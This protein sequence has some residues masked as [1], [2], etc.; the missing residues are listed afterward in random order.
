MRQSMS[1]ADYFVRQMQLWG[2]DTVF[3]VPG[4]T[5]L[6]LLESL[7]S[8]GDVRFVVCRHG[9]AAALM[10][11][12]YAKATGK[13]AACV[14]D[15]GP[16]AVQILNGVYDAYMD[17]VPVLALTG[18]FPTDRAAGR[19]PRSGD[20]RP[21]Y[22]AATVADETVRAAAE[23]PR[24][25]GGAL[26]SMA[27]HGRPVRV[28][29]PKD[30][31]AES[32]AQPQFVEHPESSAYA[33]NGRG[34]ESEYGGNVR[35]GG[36][37]YGAQ[38]R[39]KERIVARAAERLQQAQRPVLF[40]GI[41][42]A[43]AVPELLHLA[44]AL[45]APVVHSLPAAGIVPVDNG[46][47]LGVIG[48]YGTAA[49]A[50]VFGRADVVV[51][52]GTTWW[53][54]Q[55]AASDVRIIQIDNNRE[56]LGLVLPADIGVWG[57]AAIVLDMLGERIGHRH[58]ANGAS[59][60]DTGSSAEWIEFVQNARL[61]LQSEWRRMEHNQSTPLE[62]GAV[63]AAIGRSLV[64]NAIV[65]IDVGNNTFWFSRYMQ[66][67]DMKVL[68]SG[69]WRSA[70]FALPGAIAA[71]HAEPGRQVVAIGGD[72]G[73]GMMMSE[74]MTAVTYELPIVCVVLCDGRFGEEAARQ[75][76]QGRDAFGTAL[77]EPDWAAFAR[78][79]GAA[80]YTVDTVDELQR[81]LHEA[82]PALARGQISV[83]HVNVA[84]VAP[85]HPQPMRAR[86]MAAQGA[87]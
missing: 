38:V 85:L 48:K 70:G 62:P 44:N 60:G 6:P 36:S 81:A 5:V 40:A 43:G 42:A 76:G 69:H 79:C 24:L 25:L 17:R 50:D 64:P 57:D 61:A 3:G 35:V 49:A 31:W 58:P 4:D 66:G 45:Q 2:I 63:I 8:A 56:H 78:A 33:A 14:A 16:G 73:F 26:R 54:A 15:A 87:T 22:K 12:A 11:S 80:G 34:N 67:P 59:P 47:N 53:P 46:W 83:L 77:Y 75:E 37:A 68:L 82:L 72:G 18:E 84:R 28:G 51:A 74:L 52:I 71:K 27:M 41:G 30:V 86:Q 29:V 65:S 21:L 9:E 39:P 7:R 32:V 23:A 20:T 13:P 10:A 55:F 1:V 19:G